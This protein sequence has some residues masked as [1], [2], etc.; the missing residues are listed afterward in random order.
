MTIRQESTKSANPYP[1][2]STWLTETKFTETCTVPSCCFVLLTV[3]STKSSVISCIHHSNTCTIRNLSDSK[4]KTTHSFLNLENKCE[5]QAHSKAPRDSHQKGQDTPYSLSYFAYAK[6]GG[7]NKRRNRN[8]IFCKVRILEP[9]Y[10]FNM[11]VFCSRNSRGYEKCQKVLVIDLD[12]AAVETRADTRSVSA[13]NAYAGS[14][15]MLHLV[16]IREVSGKYS[17]NYRGPLGRT[18]CAYAKCQMDYI[19][20][21]VSFTWLHLVRIC[22]VSASR[23]IFK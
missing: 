21:P 4:G 20:N 18:S 10:P 9:A 6:Y 2:G 12:A 13:G 17:T 11:R 23:S 8:R 16:R 14:T 1:V 3:A 5:P 15:A 22:E 19:P 7:N